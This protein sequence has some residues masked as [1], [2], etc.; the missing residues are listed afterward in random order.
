MNIYRNLTNIYRTI[1]LLLLMI[2]CACFEDPQVMTDADDDVDG[3]GDGSESGESEGND[4]P[5]DEGTGDLPTSDMGSDPSPLEPVA[6][7]SFNGSLDDDA[8]DAHGNDPTGE[9]IFVASEGHE[10][11][12]FGTSGYVLVDNPVT[13]TLVGDE[14][15]TVA[16]QYLMWSTSDKSIIFYTG[17]PGEG[18]SVDSF[19]VHVVN[20]QF[21]LFSEALGQNHT[22]AMGPAPTPGQWHMVVFTVF[23]D[24]GRFDVYV[25]GDVTSSGEYTLPISTSDILVIGGWYGDHPFDG[26]VDHLEIY[27]VALTEEEVAAID[28]GS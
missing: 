26:I 11:V 1:A 12:V 2:P 27:D 15:F 22:A 17:E 18:I 19:G 3:D 14:P 6:S 5:T 7:W 28:W 24:D 8:G 20:D 9:V 25:D 21:E 23:P 4:D 13:K 10:G 16:M